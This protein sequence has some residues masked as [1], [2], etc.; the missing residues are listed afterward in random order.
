MRVAFVVILAGVLV[1][2][3]GCGRPPEHTNEVVSVPAATVPAAP[4]DAAWE[5]APVHVAKLLLQDLVEPRLMQASTPEVEVRSVQNGAEIAFRLEWADASLDDLPGPGRFVDGCAVQIP[6]EITAEAP[7][8]QMGDAAKPVEISFWRADWQA[9]VNGRED[10]IRSLYPHATVDHYPFEARSLEPGSAAQ[11]EMARRYAPAE[12]V[13]NRRAGPRESPVEDLL[14]LGPGTLAPN[15]AGTSRGA[16][17]R[18]AKGWTVVV[19]RAYPAGLTPALRT[20]IAFAVWEGSAREA[21]SRKMRTG[22]IPLAVR[23]AK[24]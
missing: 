4:G 12:A 16:G 13:G 19:K 10:S 6:R 7:D 17:E 20:Q 11:K 18:T 2:L 5:S 24:P 3:A 23:E 9:S 14:A 15:P 8:P 21:G 22:W 1:V